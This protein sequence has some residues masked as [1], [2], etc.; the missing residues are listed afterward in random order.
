M[1]RS[2]SLTEP[3]APAYFVNASLRVPCTQES[4]SIVGVVAGSEADMQA[5][6]TFAA[7][8]NLRVVVTN[9]G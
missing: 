7:T 1:K 3:P 8:H 4:V 6:F 9:T 5:A 2:S